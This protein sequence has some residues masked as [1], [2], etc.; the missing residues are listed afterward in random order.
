[1]SDK[2]KLYYLIGKAMSYILPILG[3]A[4]TELICL[5]HIILK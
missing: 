4:I 3:L 1:M 2:D 5:A